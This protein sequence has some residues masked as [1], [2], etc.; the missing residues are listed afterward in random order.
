[1]SDLVDDLRRARKWLEDWDPETAEVN[2]L[3]ADRIEAL[4]AEVERLRAALERLLD[5][6]ATREHEKMPSEEWDAII[7]A[8]EEALEGDETE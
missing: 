4:E 2:G 1:V 5:A 7:L 8:T 6:N 3:A